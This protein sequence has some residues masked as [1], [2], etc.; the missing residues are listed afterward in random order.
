MHSF[1]LF[2]YTWNYIVRTVLYSH[3]KKTTPISKSSTYNICMLL[4]LCHPNDN[5]IHNTKLITFE[6]N[7]WSSTSGE[8]GSQKHYCGKDFTSTDKQWNFDLKMS[9]KPKHQQ[10]IKTISGHV[11]AYGMLLSFTHLSLKKMSL[12]YL[13]HLRGHN[14]YFR[15]HLSPKL[16]PWLRPSL[17][18]VE[19]VF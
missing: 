6:M 18:L 16:R 2:I 9:L 10:Q 5:M 3:K 1:A 19:F 14:A 7:R 11:L 4:A 8:S 12:I 15:R 17:Y 13:S